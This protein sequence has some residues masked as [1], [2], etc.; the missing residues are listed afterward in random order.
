MLLV[1]S[2]AKALDFETPPP[3][4]AQGVSPFLSE[5]AQLIERLQQ[6]SPQE[7]SAL[8][9]LSPALTE[10]NVE[11]YRRWQ[12]EHNAENSRPAIFAFNGDVY[13]GLQARQLP[14]AAIEWLQRHLRILSGL[15]GVLRPLDAMQ[16]YRL[17]MGSRLLNEAGKDLYAFWR[18]KIAPLLRQELDRLADEG[19]P[20][21]LV[22]LASQEYFKAVDVR[23][24][25]APVITPVFQDRQKE[26]YRVV[27]FYAKRARGL[28]ARLLTQ[29]QATSPEE[30]LSF[31]LEGY[32]YV[33]EVSRADAPVF[34]RE[35]VPA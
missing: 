22:N 24:L 19:A 29:R 31:D 13:E 33:P 8:M 4:P 26:G 15:Y 11:R 10:L 16:P 1:I 25:G 21:V 6:L 23:Q 28:M 20:R 17:E 3:V 32:R 27:S 18:S 5:A 2:P 12:R 30:I 34:R 35:K 9:D 7:V 14:A